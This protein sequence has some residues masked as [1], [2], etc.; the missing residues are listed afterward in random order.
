MDMEV[1][2]QVLEL[3]NSN[4]SLYLSNEEA[5]KLHLILRILKGLGWDI[6]NPRDMVPEARS[7]GGGRVDYAL[8]KGGK[9][10]AYVEAKNL[11]T[12]VIKDHNALRQLGYY[13][14]NDGVRIGILTNGIQWVVIDA[15]DREKRLADRRV[16]VVDLKWLPLGENARRL[17]WLSKEKIDKLVEI[18]DNERKT[19]VDLPAIDTDRSWQSGVTQS[20]Q[21]T[22]LSERIRTLTVTEVTVDKPPTHTIDELFNSDLRG[23]RPMAV[24]VKFRETWYRLDVVGGASWRQRPRLAWSTLLPA[25]VVFL[26][27]KGVSL[28]DLR[29]YGWIDRIENIPRSSWVIYVGAGFGVRMPSDGNS[30]IRILKELIQRLEI[31]VAI[32][33]V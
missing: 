11:N 27:Q 32:T 20:I 24:Y 2:S 9:C 26:I 10:V 14:F 15:F 18:S 22:G 31:D 17:S 5:T 28:E 4:R 23:K 13:C 29:I 3:I 8:Y 7:D 33:L 19:L 6:F 30:T 12:N 16:I 1:L 25:V 21:K